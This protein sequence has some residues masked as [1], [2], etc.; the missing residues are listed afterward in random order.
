[1][2]SLAVLIRCSRPSPPPAKG[3]AGGVGGGWGVGEGWLWL[4]ILVP[5][6]Y[7]D[8]VRSAHVGYLQPVVCAVLVCLCKYAS[9]VLASHVWH[10]MEALVHAYM[11]N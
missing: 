2:P 7:C 8:P 3:S 9:R 6:L 4:I 10:I 5:L 1:M 11:D